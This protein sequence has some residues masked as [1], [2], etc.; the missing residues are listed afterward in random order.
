MFDIITTTAINTTNATTTTTMNCN[1][2]VYFHPF[3]NTKAHRIKFIWFLIVACSQ[4][5]NS[6]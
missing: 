3:S 2:N 5:N 1:E 6:C 4:G